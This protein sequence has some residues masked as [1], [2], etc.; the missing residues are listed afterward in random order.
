MAV[1]M[2][3]IAGGV[4]AFAASSGTSDGGGSAREQVKSEAQARVD[5]TARVQ[6]RGRIAGEQLR[7]V[8]LHRGGVTRVQALPT[9]ADCGQQ[10]DYQDLAK[11]FGDKH[12]VDF[13]YGCTHDVKLAQLEP[14]GTI[15]EVG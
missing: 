11:E 4:V 10:W 2:L 15:V 14:G 7:N 9:E 5:E 12:R 3:A 8:R 13:V 1:V 6:E